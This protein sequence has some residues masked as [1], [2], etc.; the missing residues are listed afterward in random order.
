MVDIILNVVTIEK[1]YL[2]A[3][4]KACAAQLGSNSLHQTGLGTDRCNVVPSHIEAS[5]S[6]HPP[7]EEGCE[8]AAAFG[9]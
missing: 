6:A 1:L 5:V 9:V 8:A 7:P 4:A 3:G 2:P